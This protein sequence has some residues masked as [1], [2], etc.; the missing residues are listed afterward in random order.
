MKFGSS[1]RAPAEINLTPLMDILFLVLVFLVMT[2]TFT[3]RTFVDIDLPRAGTGAPEGTEPNVIRI[4]VDADGRVY[5]EGQSVGLEGARQW[6]LAM[7]RQGAM[8]VVLAADERT[9]HGQVI[10]VIDMV[11]ESS[12]TRVHIETVPAPA[13]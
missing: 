1:E 7:P 13:P 4:D 10:Q 12:I 9:P 11:R 5:L 3:R 6:L 2:A 8:T